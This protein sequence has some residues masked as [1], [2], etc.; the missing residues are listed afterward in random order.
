[1]ELLDRLKQ[2]A[3]SDES[4]F[5][6]HLAKE[7]IARLEK[8]HALALASADVEE[9]RKSGFYLGWT[10]ADMRTHDLRESLL[11]LLDAYFSS[12]RHP[13]DADQE[14][15]LCAAWEA[16]DRDRLKKLLHCL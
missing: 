10:Q 13:D 14:R 11:V 15:L 3:T 5:R 8:L 1:M 12:A 2:A 4:F 16:F 6:R 9:F 7:D